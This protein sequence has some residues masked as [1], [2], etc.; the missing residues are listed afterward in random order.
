[1]HWDP[2]SSDSIEKYVWLS[3]CLIDLCSFLF[4]VVAVLWHFFFRR[5]CR[6]F[7]GYSCSECSR[8]F[9]W[10]TVLYGCRECDH[11]LCQRCMSQQAG[12]KPPDPAGADLDAL[13]SLFFASCR[14]IACCCCLS[15]DPPP[16]LF[17]FV[18]LMQ[19]TYNRIATKN[20]TLS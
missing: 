19:Q 1:M 4:V 15:F 17:C 16:P 9:P 18:L 6:P 5:L 2:F 13:V 10:Y 7:D 14:F 3:H 12:L 8:S 20:L 11:D